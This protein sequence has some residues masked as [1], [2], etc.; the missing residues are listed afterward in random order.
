MSG[1]KATS[2]SVSMHRTQ[3]TRTPRGNMSGGNLRSSCSGPALDPIARTGVRSSS[4][5]QAM[6]SWRM[7][8]PALHRR[9]SQL[10]TD[11]P[12]SQQLP[13]SARQCRSMCALIFSLACDAWRRSGVP[14]PEQGYMRFSP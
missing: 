4:G 10:T 3:G 9:M 7:A 11:E 12:S 1:A 13:L 8:S 2:K 6:P 14:G 5:L